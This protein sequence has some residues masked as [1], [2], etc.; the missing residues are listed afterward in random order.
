VRTDSGSSAPWTDEIEDVVTFAEPFAERVQGHRLRGLAQRR[1]NDRPEPPLRA[2]DLVIDVDSARTSPFGAKS[3]RFSGTSLQQMRAPK[4]ALPSKSDRPPVEATEIPREQ[5]DSSEKSGVPPV[6][7]HK[8]LP[9][10]SREARA[11]SSR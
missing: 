4:L 11:R 10:Q 9:R 7:S 3:A 2:V 5:D 1:R 8:G 6:G